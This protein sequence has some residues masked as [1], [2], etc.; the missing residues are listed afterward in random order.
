M[1][2]LEHD[3]EVAP[4][5]QPGRSALPDERRPGAPA[6]DLTEFVTASRWNSALDGLIRFGRA[7]DLEQ[8]GKIER[9]KAIGEAR[10]R[11]LQGRELAPA[12]FPQHL[13]KAARI[14]ADDLALARVQALFE[15]SAPRLLHLLDD[16]L[17]TELKRRL[18]PLSEPMDQ[19]R[20]WLAPLCPDN[21]LGP[22]GV[23]AM[24]SL[25]GLYGGIQ[26]FAEQAAVLREALVTD[27]ARR[28]ELGYGPEP[29]K[30]GCK[31][32][33][34]EAERAWKVPVARRVELV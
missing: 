16:P 22:E 27:F 24:A 7:D 14:F 1:V 11:G 17:M 2:A 13:G 28:C 10:A 15:Q 33:R 19:V 26:R 12:E 32:V 18:P 6:W 4:R 8:L 21:V 29:G 9:R 20:C 31:A 3:G 23:S 34:L 5:V 30:R 25:A